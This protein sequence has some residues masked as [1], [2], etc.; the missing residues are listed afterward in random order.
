MR[1]EH[2]RSVL[3]RGWWGC[4]PH[5]WRKGPV[6]HAIAWHAC[7]CTC[8]CACATVPGACD[9]AIRAPKN[10]T[11]RGNCLEAKE[12]PL[13]WKKS[14]MTG[15]ARPWSWAYYANTLLQACISFQRAPAV[16]AHQRITPACASS[17]A[18]APAQAAS[19]S[20]LPSLPKNIL[21]SPH[22]SPGASGA[23]G[24][25]PRRPR[26]AGRRCCSRQSKGG[27][28]AAR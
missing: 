25:G 11:Q 27:A 3:R 15:I 22:P 26:G 10:Q 14:H 9:T 2:T 18:P 17:T 7:V 13:R 12:V 6:R 8:L 20:F 19:R 23:L 24:G 28:A 21:M 1:P 4:M 16:H 5:L